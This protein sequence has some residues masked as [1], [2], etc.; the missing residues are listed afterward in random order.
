MT[1]TN[2]E[3]IFGTKAGIVWKALD[4]NGPSNIGDLVKATSLSREEVNVALGW[5]GREDKILAERHG[6][7]LVFSLREKEARPGGSMAKQ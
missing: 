2:V 6:R 5:L 1:E 7:V 3:S 4:Q